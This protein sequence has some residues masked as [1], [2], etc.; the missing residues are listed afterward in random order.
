MTMDGA[1][2]GHPLGQLC[3]VVDAQ[4][5]LV[6]PRIEHEIGQLVQQVEAGAAHRGGHQGLRPGSCHVGRD[7]PCARRASSIMTDHDTCVRFMSSVREPVTVGVDIGTTSVK[8]LA[9]DENGQVVARS[10]VPHGVVAPEPDMLR[11][12]AKRAWRAGPAQGL[13]AGDGPA[14]RCKRDTAR[15][16]R[17]G[18]HGALAHRGQP[19]GRAAAARPALRGPRGPG[20][21]EET[22][23]RTFCFA[24]HDARR[25]GLPA[26]GARRG[27]R[28]PGLLA[29]PGRGDQCALGHAGHRH[30]RHRRRWARCTPTGA[31]TPSSWRRSMG[32][33]G[34][35]AHGRADG[36]GRRHAA[37]Q[38]HRHHGW[39]HRRPVRPDR[40]G[41]DAAGRRAGHLRRDPDRVGGLRRV[42]RRRRG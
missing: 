32:S 37:R 9:V 5:G 1:L 25:R 14:R 18:L 36:R 40:G 15:R 19:P 24:G 7:S 17:R 3:G 23:R 29:V 8:A 26:L 13:R 21:P 22:V 41:G 20:H 6:E 42:A 12:D 16:C 27:A 28:R 11:H 4:G 10:R 39:H 2:G 33:R 34:A 31:G 35:D 38:R 30:R